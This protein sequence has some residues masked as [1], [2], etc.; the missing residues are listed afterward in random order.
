MRLGTLVVP[1]AILD[2]FSYVVQVDGFRL[3]DVDA[4]SAV[5]AGLAAHE[6]RDPFDRLIAS[7]ALGLGAT[8][9]TSDPAIAALGA[10]VYW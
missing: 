4:S 2:D 10:T 6:H 5:R 3:L 9:V 1:P 8:V 7:Q